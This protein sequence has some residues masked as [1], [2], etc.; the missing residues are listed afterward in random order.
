[1]AR[2]SCCPILSISAPAAIL[3]ITAADAPAT[4]AVLAQAAGEQ[5]HVLRERVAYVHWS[6]SDTGIA[7]AQLNL[8]GR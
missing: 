7:S 6:M 3:W 1:M 4:A 8:P 2:T 5:I